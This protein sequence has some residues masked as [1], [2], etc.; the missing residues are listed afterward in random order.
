M[1]SRDRAIGTG[2][3]ANEAVH[4]TAAHRHGNDMSYRPKSLG[5][6]LQQPA[7]RVAEVKHKWLA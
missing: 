2:K 4:P 6:Y 3:A 1:K 7:A 5:A